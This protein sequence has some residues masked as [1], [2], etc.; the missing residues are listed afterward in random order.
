MKIARVQVEEGFLD[1]LDL[2][3]SGGLNTIIGARGTG[4]TSI[5]ELI[6][7]GLGGASNLS[8][9]QE[10]SDQH[11]REILGTSGRVT[12][13]LETNDGQSVVCSRSAQEQNP[14]KSGEY[15]D[16]IVFS[17]TEIE[18]LGK[19]PS[20]RLK[21]ID[22]FVPENPDKVDE[23][24]IHAS[25]I[26]SLTSEIS[27]K[28]KNLKE[29][30]AEWNQLPELRKDLREMES[31]EE[32]VK[33]SSE[34]MSKNYED[35][36][37]INFRISENSVVEDHLKRILEVSGR[38]VSS[39]RELEQEWSKVVNPTTFHDELGPGNQLLA[40]AIDAISVA[41]DKLSKADKYFRA[42]R[43]AREA[44]RLVLE[45][46]AR[47][48][49][50][51]IERAEAGFGE[52]SRNAQ[53]LRDKIAQLDSLSALVEQ[54]K[55]SIAHL[56]EERSQRLDELTA[57]RSRRF[58]ARTEVAKKLNS[59][60]APA[61]KIVVANG[62]DT[63]RYKAELASQLKGSGLRYSEL[64]GP[65]SELME[66]RELVEWVEANDHQSLADALDV[67]LDRAVRLISALET[68][69]LGKIASFDIGDT[70]AFYLRD[71]ADA[72]PISELSV[73]QRCT[74]VLPIVLQI[75]DTVII[76]DQ[77]EDHI[78]NAFIAE[79][80]IRAI[81]ERAGDSQLLVTTH[82]AN[83]PVL[84][85][86]Q[87]VTVLDS[88]GRRGFVLFSH[89]LKAGDVVDAISSLM[90]G[91]KQAFDARAKFYEGEG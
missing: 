8:M 28:T 59:K 89:N 9:N 51:T 43:A 74:V 83:I 70:V 90:E 62:D 56:Q 60:L 73:G 4:K 19:S 82:N 1:G 81:K 33:E 21:L 13:T 87:Q 79:T 35:L 29:L 24:S 65:L 38:R 32:A 48:L 75:T 17:Q 67:S 63:E 37:S 54:E 53:R 5:V 10:L 46:A 76:L 30:E 78:D 27:Y 80:L 57:L 14:R 42:T 52:V 41:K 61:I 64:I 45:D 72:K 49:R 66:P 91:G 55:R 50:V 26:S 58:D 16:P 2:R 25:R 36:K 34:L 31:R 12:V 44:D 68:V 15:P 3:L 85:E 11:A 6:R 69:D 77:P 86:S 47:S 84:G 7:F 40:D 88:D 71:G 20:G 23:E 39:L 18:T 22:R